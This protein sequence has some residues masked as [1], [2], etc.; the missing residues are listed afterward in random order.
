MFADSLLEVSWA[1]RGRRGWMTLTSFGL[2]A[3]IIGLLLMI[4]LLTTVGSPL[5]RTVSTPITMGRRSPRPTTQPHQGNVRNTGVRTIPYSGPI[6]EPSHINPGIPK[7]DGAIASGPT[8][9]PDIGVG[10]YIGEGPNLPISISGN[11]HVVMPSVTRLDTPVFR[12]SEILEGMLIRKVEP[13]YPPLAITARIQGS[14]VLA[15]MISK[16]GE[17]E[18]LRLVSGQPML[19]RSAIDAV[20]QWRYRPFILNGDVIEVETQITVN[21]VLGQ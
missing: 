3:A 5:A 11:R 2:E 10:P 6:L 4:P 13:K 14:V 12:R 19:V 7:D 1:E 8:G 20:S 18:N 9:P 17:I 21:F 16:S 15:A